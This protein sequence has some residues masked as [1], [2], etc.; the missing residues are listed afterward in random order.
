MEEIEKHK[1]SIDELERSKN[2]LQ[3][4]LCLEISTIDTLISAHKHSI[5]KIINNT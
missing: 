4:I 2:R 3:E 1:Y 5:F